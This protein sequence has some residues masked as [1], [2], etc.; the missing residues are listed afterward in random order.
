MHPSRGQQFLWRR[1]RSRIISLFLRCTA[2]GN[3]IHIFYL[4]YYLALSWL[5]WLSQ[6]TASAKTFIHFYKF[7]VPSSTTCSSVCQYS[8]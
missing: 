2:Q 7:F 5:S 3:H 6:I 4:L 8:Y 1:T